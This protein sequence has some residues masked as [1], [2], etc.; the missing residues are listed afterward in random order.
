MEGLATSPCAEEFVDWINDNGFILFNH[1]AEFTFFHRN[2]AYSPTI[3]D[4][5]FANAH[6]L[7]RHWDVP[8]AKHIGSD[9]CTLAW[10]IDKT[11]Q[12]EFELPNFS[13]KDKT[14]RTG[15]QSSKENWQYHSLSI[16]QTP[17]HI[18]IRQLL[19]YRMQ[20]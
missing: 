13:I 16:F 12:D 6:S 20:F 11:F 8:I 2:A 5:T 17:Q 19:L 18:L 1:P 15:V 4:L 7:I 3:I 9:H 10:D 14:R